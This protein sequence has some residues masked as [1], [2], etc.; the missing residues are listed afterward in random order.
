MMIHEWRV[1]THIQSTF[2]PFH[3][4]LFIEHIIFHFEWYRKGHE[5]KI[6]FTLHDDSW[7]FPSKFNFNKFSIFFLHCIYRIWVNSSFQQR[8]VGKS[9]WFAKLWNWEK[10]KEDVHIKLVVRVLF[11]REIGTRGWIVGDEGIHFYPTYQSHL[12]NKNIIVSF[13]WRK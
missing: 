13:S 10:R 1:S 3:L 8:K 6:T 2:F 9:A 12:P 7:Q 11:W 5:R 4:S